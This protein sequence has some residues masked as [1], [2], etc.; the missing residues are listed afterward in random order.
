MW[1]RFYVKPF[2]AG[3]GVYVIIN[4]VLTM[5]SNSIVRD[6]LWNLLGVAGFLIPVFQILAGSAKLVGMAINK[7]NWEAAGLIM[8]A[9]M[10]FIRALLWGAGLFTNGPETLAEINSLTVALLIVAANIVRLTQIFNGYV[11][12]YAQKVEDLTNGGR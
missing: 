9:A 7:A 6:E 11:T 2:E 3:V 10:F 8:V 1:R 12:V 5:F 4:G